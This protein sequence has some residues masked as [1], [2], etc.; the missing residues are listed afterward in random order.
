MA[1]KKSAALSGA[2]LRLGRR[3]EQLAAQKLAAAGYAILACNYRCPAGEIDLVARQND[4]LVFV[5]VRTRRGAAFGLPEESLTARKRRHLITAAQHYVQ[6]HAPAQA[7]WRIDFVA[8]EFSVRGELKRIEII[9]N[10][11]HE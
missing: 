8:V 11:I 3:G 5:E 1:E 6:A 2:R 9:E 4:T 10:A 7:A